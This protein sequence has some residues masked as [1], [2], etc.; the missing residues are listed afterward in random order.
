PTIFPPTS[1][2]VSHPGSGLTLPLRSTSTGYFSKCPLIS[3]TS[4]DANWSQLASPIDL[5]RLAHSRDSGRVKHSYKNPRCSA[6]RDILYPYIY[7][8]K[9]H[10]VEG[11][12]QNSE[13]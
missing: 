11:Q 8:K 9:M 1:G 3:V 2:K 5:R 12:L 6:H 7:K 13:I 10:V 4:V